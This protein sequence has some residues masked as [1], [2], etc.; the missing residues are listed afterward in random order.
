MLLRG[1]IAVGVASSVG[2]VPGP[3]HHEIPPSAQG[4]RARSCHP[5]ANLDGPR[6]GVSANRIGWVH[7]PSRH[8]LRALSGQRQVSW[9]GRQDALKLLIGRTQVL[10]SQW[11]RVLYWERSYPLSSNGLMVVGIFGHPQTT[12]DGLDQRSLRRD[13][14]LPSGVW[15]KTASV[16]EPWSVALACEESRL[17]DDNQIDI[18]FEGQE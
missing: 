7:D 9:V 6:R 1:A 5:S 4:I 17:A 2:S 11:P 12:Q 3:S 13:F 10:V 16:G 18:M 8:G 14:D 15:P